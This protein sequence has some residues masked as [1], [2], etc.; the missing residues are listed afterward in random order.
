MSKIKQYSSKTGDF[1]IDMY[2][3]KTLYEKLF[4]SFKE[5]I[6]PENKEMSSDICI[7]KQINEFNN[8]LENIKEQN[9]EKKIPD[10][11]SKN[12]KQ[13]KNSK[14][15]YFLA[16][17][18]IYA[19]NIYLYSLRKI[20]NIKN[21]IKKLKNIKQYLSNFEQNA[22]TGIFFMNI[23][24]DSEWYNKKYSNPHLKFDSETINFLFYDK[25]VIWYNDN[26]FKHKIKPIFDEF[27]NK[28]SFKH[29]NDSSDYNV[30][31]NSLI[32]EIINKF[33]EKLKKINYE[34][35]P[36]IEL[37]PETEPL[38]KRQRTSGGGKRILKKYF[39]K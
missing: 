26:L 30:I 35:S 27:D 32:L 12:I 10:L 34:S 37:P 33:I 9:A 1:N 7:T 6:K 39:T 16:N 17:I 31:S 14:Y 25:F 8:Y 13:R 29:P 5:M 4:N 11:D 19:Y 15:V 36:E 38:P 18:L 20:E 3:N 23:G 21:N 24:L 28:H 2:I 22:I